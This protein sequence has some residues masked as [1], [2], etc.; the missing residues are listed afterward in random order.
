M[1]KIFNRKL[2]KSNQYWE[3]ACNT[4]LSGTQLYSKG[5][6]THIKGVSP[7]YIE[8]GKDAHV[9]DPDGNE[10]IDYDMGL[11]PI[12]LGYSYE[13]VDN[14][15]IEQMKKGMGFSLVSPIEVEYAE[16]CIEN[17]PCAEKVRFLKTGSSATEG[18]IRIARAYTGKKHIIRGEYHGWHEWTVA[19][20]S[21]RQGG[22]LPELKQ[23]VHKFEYND[24]A[25]LEKLFEQY[26]DEIAAVIIEPV[27]LEE[28][29]NN[30]LQNALDIC[31]K[32]GAILIFDEV[33]TGFR[34]SIGGAQKYFGITPDL[35][36]FGKGAAN[37]MPLSIIA[38]KR[39]IMDDVDKKI[40]ISTTFGGETLSLAAGIEVMNE[41][42]NKDVTERIWSLGKKIKEES[43]AM[44]E[45]IGVNIRLE[46]YHCRMAFDYKDNNG[47]RDWLYNSIFMQE[48]V[49]RG[50]LLGWSIFPCYTHTDKDIDFTLNVFEDAMRVYKKAIESGNPAS[51]MEGEPL[52]IVLG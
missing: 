41:L 44:A 32:N 6:E 33:V 42:K 7:I 24:F 12:L 8:K 20:E 38:G 40:F 2:Y 21:V 28:P 45:R 11:G 25:T 31:H 1:A 48:C 15:V 18:A 10:Y 46:G 13:P 35:A 39:E 9:W 14:A 27:I 52:K 23:Y 16:L 50:V 47:K 17:I 49:K 34:F 26:K 5:P 29:E 19:G 30:F 4:I 36:T 37:G 51:Y 43:N 3:K 22:I